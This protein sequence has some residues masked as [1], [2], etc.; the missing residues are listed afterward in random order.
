MQKERDNAAAR[1]QDTEKLIT[2]LKTDAVEAWVNEVDIKF[3][4]LIE[5]WMIRIHI[6]VPKVS[7]YWVNTAKRRFVTWWNRLPEK[8]WNN[9]LRLELRSGADC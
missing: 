4:N 2:Q 7:S 3:W 5:H 8:A 6:R 9:I 1:Q